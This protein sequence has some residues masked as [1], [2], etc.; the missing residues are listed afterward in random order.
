MSSTQMVLSKYVHDHYML[1]SGDGK[2][3]KIKEGRLNKNKKFQGTQRK[4][5]VLRS[6][7][8]L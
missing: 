6:H 8:G 2:K 4:A 3:N 7:T 1:K 5:E